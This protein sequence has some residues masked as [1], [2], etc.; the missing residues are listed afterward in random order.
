LTEPPQHPAHELAAGGLGVQDS[1]GGEGADHPPDP[2]ESE[3]GVDGDLRELGPEGRHRVAG[4]RAGGVP[5]SQRFDVFPEI[6]VKQVAVAL[7]DLGLVAQRH[8]AVADDHGARVGAVQGEAE[9]VGQFVHRGLHREHPGRLAG[10]ARERRPHGVG[11]DEPVA[12]LAI[13]VGVR[14][15]RDAERRLGPSRRTARSPR[16]C[17]GEAW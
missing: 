16:A 4:V 5:A 10:A 15:R 1:A 11:V 8:P 2:D 3:V 13:R 9:L 12:A 17:G 14:L 6:A 7:A